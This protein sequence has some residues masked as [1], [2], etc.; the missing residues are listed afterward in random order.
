MDVEIERLMLEILL[1]Q[2]APSP[3]DNLSPRRSPAVGMKPNEPGVPDGRV[4]RP[5]N[6]SRREF[7]VFKPISMAFRMLIARGP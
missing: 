7:F 6:Q 2:P 3:Q 5:Y 1:S 4:P